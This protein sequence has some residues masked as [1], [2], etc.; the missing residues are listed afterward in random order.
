MG[1]L[2]SPR[3]V[4]N[5]YF[6]RA[7]AVAGNWAFV[8]DSNCDAIAADSSVKREGGVVRLIYYNQT[9]SKW[10]YA[11]DADKDPIS[12]TSNDIDNFDAFG[13]SLYF[14]Q[15]EE[16][17]DRRFLIVTALLDDTL[18][19]NEPAQNNGSVYFYQVPAE[20]ELNKLIGCAKADLPALLPVLK[21]KISLD[22]NDCPNLVPGNGYMSEFLPSIAN[23]TA[24][25]VGEEIPVSKLNPG[26]G[27]GATV[28][29]DAD[30]EVLV[31]GAPYESY[32]KDIQMTG[33]LILLNRPGAA[34]IFEP[35]VSGAYDVWHL[36]A[37]LMPMWNQPQYANKKYYDTHL[38][39]LGETVIPVMDGDSQKFLT[40]HNDRA[41]YYF[42]E[43]IAVS[44]DTIAIGVPNAAF[45]YFRKEGAGSPANGKWY[46]SNRNEIEA[47]T[48]AI[49]K[50]TEKNQK[51]G[52]VYVYHKVGSDWKFSQRCDRQQ[53]KEQ[54]KNTVPGTYITDSDDFYQYGYYDD[55]DLGKCVEIY[56]DYILAGIPKSD[57]GI[58][59]K[60]DVKI[61]RTWNDI[62]SIAFFKKNDSAPCQLSTKIQQSEILNTDYPL[63][64]D[65]IVRRKNILAVA[66]T[67]TDYLA[68]QKDC[69]RVFF[70]E[71]APD[72]SSISEVSGTYAVTTKEPTKGYQ[73][74]GQYM[75]F[76]IENNQVI[77]GV[78]E[79]GINI[80]YNN[81]HV[82]KYWLPNCG[83]LYTFKWKN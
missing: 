18:Y 34:Y 38:Q 6:G 53:F 49:N 2:F 47:P 83:A 29:Y 58:S 64:A 14:A 30:A 43:N 65:Q 35:A 36:K 40:R 71:I 27:F 10:C 56:G 55:E 52:T 67:G 26:I 22:K 70:Y 82:S 41:D 59:G 74:L 21:A 3:I 63:W 68:F 76:S 73:K 24:A 7:V 32:Y 20:E 46:D 61:S 78:P 48:E 45:Q 17:P 23:G 9:E 51:M 72:G 28:R 60:K 81:P 79:L 77:C 13:S 8:G 80:Y 31:V 16:N 57:K 44:K 15:G 12:F 19:G 75:D 37:R 54:Y 39:Y 50:Y 33:N 66:A 1:V 11:Y 25:N 42:G 5:G 62:G 69:G 4:A